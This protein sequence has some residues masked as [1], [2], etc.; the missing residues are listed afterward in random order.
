M[1][2]PIDEVGGG[3]GG[4]AELL[5]PIAVVGGGEEEEAAVVEDEGRGIGSEE[6]MIVDSEGIVEGFGR[7]GV[8]YFCS[9]V[10]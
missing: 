4:P 8:F 7:I 6:G 10:L 5:F 2:F 3:V 1:V 9:F